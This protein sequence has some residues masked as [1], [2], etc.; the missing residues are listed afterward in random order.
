MGADG[1]HSRTRELVF[2]PESRWA[3]HLGFTMACY[4]VPD[5]AGLTDA[6]VHFAEPRLSAMASSPWSPD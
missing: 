2:G 1:V 6:C 3:C 4:P 5:I